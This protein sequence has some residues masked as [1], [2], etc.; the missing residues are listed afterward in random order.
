MGTKTPSFGSGKR[1]SHDASD[2]YK[3]NLASGGFVRAVQPELSSTDVT[4][5]LYAHTSEDMH[6]LPDNSVGL[7]VTS[8]PYHVGKDYDTT[9]SFDDYLDLLFRVFEE[10]FRVMEPGGRVVIN[11]AGLGR[12]P[13]VHLPTFINAIMLEIGFMP[14]GEVIWVKAAGASGS[15]A[16]GSFMKASNPVLRDL[17]EHLLVFCKGWENPKG[18]VQWGRYK[19]GESTVSKQEF[20]DYTLSVWNMPPESAKR[21]G[22]PAPFPK[23]LPRRFIELYSYKGDVILDPFIGAG[24]T[25]VAAL[26]AGRKYVGYDTNPAYLTIAKHRLKE[27][28][29]SM[30]CDAHLQSW[31]DKT[32]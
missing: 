3:R 19:A 5:G 22:H 31:K 4:S 21:V 13:Y 1:E 27:A 28:G 32:K 24:A 10:T 8:P 18:E 20:L 16:W 11:A 7:M 23:E 29:Q 25:A 14:R 2:F 17:H 15:C 30:I 12:S 6:E 9:D 26:A